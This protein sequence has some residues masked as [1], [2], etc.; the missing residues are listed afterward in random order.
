MHDDWNIWRFALKKKKRWK[1]TNGEQ[2]KS[3]I[4]I[5]NYIIILRNTKRIYFVFQCA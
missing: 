4:K 5:K 3:N 1:S 2:Q